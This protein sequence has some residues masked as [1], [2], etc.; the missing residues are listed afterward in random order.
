MNWLSRFVFFSFMALFAIALLP[1]CEYQGSKIGQ[2]YST[3]DLETLRSMANGGSADAQFALA[4]RFH[5]GDGVAQDFESAIFWY[6]K[7]VKSGHLGAMN[8]L[9]GL[10]Y[11]GKGAKQDFKRA[12]ELYNKIYEAGDVSGIAALAGMYLDGKGVAQ[13]YKE[14]QRLYLLA[15]QKGYGPAQT[16][17]G[18]MYKFGWGVPQDDVE[19]YSWWSLAA[20]TGDSVALDNLKKLRQR[21][22]LAELKRAEERSKQFVIEKQ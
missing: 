6:E 11:D 20:R 9:A 1:S 7:A 15:A 8:N 21:L 13:D 17:L 4:V 18:M 3:I 22:S 10:Y 14:A 2:N 16:A 19:A 12:I 5:L